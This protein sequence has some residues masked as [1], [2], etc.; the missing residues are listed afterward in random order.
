MPYCKADLRSI[1]RRMSC[2]SDVLG[3]TT[4]DVESLSERVV[5]AKRSVGGST[6]FAGVGEKR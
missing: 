6:G 4:R 5:A 1:L 2:E 3:T